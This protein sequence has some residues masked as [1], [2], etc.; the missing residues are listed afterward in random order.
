MAARPKALDLKSI[1]LFSACTGSELRRIRSSLDEVQVP[2]GK[3]LVEEGRIGV[4]FFLI[5]DGR[6]SVV[7][8]GRKVATLGPGDYF[9]ELA[10]LDR[11]P[12]SASVISET[13]MD[14]LVLHQRQFNG[15]LESVP[16]ISRKLL[17]AMANRLREADAKAD[18]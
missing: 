6:A 18:R 11:R 4:E 7:R 9:G 1:W 14:V 10:L 15:L 2:K 8:N 17:A 3:V 12:R 5:V 16:N 13:D